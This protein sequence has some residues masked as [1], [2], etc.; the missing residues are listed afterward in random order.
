LVFYPLLLAVLIR[1]GV[2]PLAA[3]LMAQFQFDLVPY[4]PL[5]MSFVLLMT[6]ML[7]GM[8][9]GF[10]LLDQRDDQTLTALQVTPLTLNGYLVYRIS[11]PIVLSLVITLIIFPMAG[12]VEIGFVPLLLAALSAA[13]L[14]PFY[15]L[16][17]AA[18]AANK[19]QGF[20]LTKALGV[21]LVPPVMAYFVP[22]PW[23]WAFGLVPLYW[24]AKLIWLLHAGETSYWFYLLIGLLYQFL[25]LIVLLRRF[26]K[27]MHL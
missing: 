13:P 22:T 10:L 16:S 12:L 14:A 23:Q 27:A 8:V 17:L 1:W 3:R 21:L 25:L 18:I 5:L 4:Y 7:A 9:I 11:M 20:A 24:P 19:V 2:P 26:N 6:P 15:A